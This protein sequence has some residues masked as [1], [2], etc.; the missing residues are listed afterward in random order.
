MMTT[1]DRDLF[2]QLTRVCS[3]LAFTI[4]FSTFL[5]SCVNYSDIPSHNKLSEVLE[6][7]C[8]SKQVFTFLLS[9][10]RSTLLNA[11]PSAMFKHLCLNRLSFSKVFFLLIFVIWWFWQALHLWWDLPALNEMRK[12]YEYLLHIPDVRNNCIKLYD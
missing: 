12:Y 6:P 5:V 3:T 4:I 2:R 11:N 10:N 9:V 8:L 1:H 7:Q